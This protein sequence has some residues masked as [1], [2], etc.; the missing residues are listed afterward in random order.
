MP[1]TETSG[2]SRAGQR[3]MLWFITLWIASVTLFA[4]VVSVLRVA[5]QY[6]IGL[7]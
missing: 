5:L 7:N 2:P 1:P 4:I 3:Q 6:T